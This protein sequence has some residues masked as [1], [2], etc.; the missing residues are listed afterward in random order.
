MG[1][2]YDQPFQHFLL[3]TQNIQ[4]TPADDANLFLATGK[5]AFNMIMS[6]L[7]I[8]ELQFQSY[9]II[10]IRFVVIFVLMMIIFDV[11]EIISP[12]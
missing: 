12:V 6:C 10:T 9:C 1:L 3:H 5:T 4:R 11:H 8:P 7:H 2:V